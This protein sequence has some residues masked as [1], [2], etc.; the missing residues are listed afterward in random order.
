MVDT[1]IPPVV[2]TLWRVLLVAAYLVFV[3]T[4]VY[5]L[6]TLWRT[7]N[8]IRNYARESAEAAEAIERNT[9]AIP[10]LDATIA[11]TTEVLTAAEAVAS[12]LDTA[13]SA[14]DARARG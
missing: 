3:P 9:A 10:A 6:H 2:F 11:V 12:K 13:A 4:A 7:A 1:A 14:L 8:S 5:W